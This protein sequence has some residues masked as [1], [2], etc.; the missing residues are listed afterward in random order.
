[1]QQADAWLE[2]HGMALLE[3]LDGLTGVT[4]GGFFGE[5][6]ELSRLPVGFSFRLQLLLQLQLQTSALTV[7]TD[8]VHFDSFSREVR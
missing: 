4:D 5:A 7:D 8:S 1:M 3:L 2:V 6:S